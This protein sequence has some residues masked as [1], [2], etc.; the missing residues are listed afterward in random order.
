MLPGFRRQLT[1]SD[2]YRMRLPRRFWEAGF[3]SIQA[4]A[5]NESA[6]VL[7][8]RYLANLDT[9]VSKGNGIMFLGSDGVGKTCAAAVL[10]KETRR[11]GGT[12]LFVSARDITDG[13]IQK[14]QFDDDQDLWQRACGVDMLVLDELGREHSGE[15]HSRQIEALMRSRAAEQRST[16]ATT[17]VRPEKLESV[18]PSAML[19]S[20]KE[21]MVFV[22]LSGDDMRLGSSEALIASVTKG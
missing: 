22:V 3:Q 13:V 5:G 17:N 10:A 14:A 6:R 15:W 9:M 1:E 16:I 2:L 11:R 7:V 8:S 12:V 20:I 19:S 21:C 18:F 4:L